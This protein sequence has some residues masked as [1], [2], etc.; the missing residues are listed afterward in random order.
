TV[1]GVSA[2]P[3]GLEMIRRSGAFTE[4]RIFVAV[5]T[6]S[7]APLTVGK[8][9]ISP[10]SRNSPSGKFDAE[11][12]GGGWPVPVIRYEKNAFCVAVAVAGLVI[13]G[14]LATATLRTRRLAESQ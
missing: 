5:S 12:S 9:L 3:V 13:V 4:P 1:G 2:V 6:I 11:K 8:P 14:A 7:V 10:L